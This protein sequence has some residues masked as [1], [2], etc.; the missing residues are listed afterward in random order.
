MTKC[1]T[2]Q[3]IALELYT[4][5]EK[6]EEM[7]PEEKL[8]VVRKYFEAEFPN[9]TVRDED[10]S[11]YASQTF[12]FM[13]KNKRLTVRY[14]F[15]RESTPPEIAAFLKISDI[16]HQLMQEGVTRVVVENDGHLTLEREPDP[17]F[18]IRLEK[19][20]GPR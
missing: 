15:F 8:D 13:G 14:A 7:I 3:N 10:E 16:S 1:L 6:E 20:P 11:N 18:V 5:L 4:R 2:T 9:S 12:S 17:R 19:E